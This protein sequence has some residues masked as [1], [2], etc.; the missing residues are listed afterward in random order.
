MLSA[1]MIAFCIFG[2]VRSRTRRIP[3]FIRAT[4]S[5][6]W[7]ELTCVAA[8][9]ANPLSLGSASARMVPVGVDNGNLNVLAVAVEEQ[10]VGAHRAPVAVG[11]LVGNRE[12][13]A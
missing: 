5:I 7:K 10:E 12:S 8:N 9:S 6:R 11:A 13:V 2:S 3:L 4:D 1:S